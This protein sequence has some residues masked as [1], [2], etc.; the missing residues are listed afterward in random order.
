[1]AS[2]S[3][4][5]IFVDLRRTTKLITPH[6]N[7]EMITNFAVNNNSVM[8]LDLKAGAWASMITAIK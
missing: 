2:S 4:D 7:K 3:L 1:M 8:G 5:L 6:T